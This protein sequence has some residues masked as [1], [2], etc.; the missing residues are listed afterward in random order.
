M[1]TTVSTILTNKT[2]TTVVQSLAFQEIIRFV[3][4]SK[5]ALVLPYVEGLTAIILNSIQLWLLVK[6]FPR[7]AS[8]LLVVIKHL[9]TSDLLNGVFYLLVPT[10][11]LIETEIFPENKIFLD[12]AKFVTV[13]SRRYVITVS[14]FLLC[15]LTLKKML[16]IVQNRSYTRLMLRNS[17]LSA[18][19]VTFALVGIEFVIEETDVLTTVSLTTLKKIWVPLVIFPSIILQFYCYWQIFIVVQ[20][21]S[22]RIP[23]RADGST[24]NNSSWQK[25]AAFQLLVFI[26]C[27][28]PLSFY[29]ILLV[30]RG[31]KNL[32]NAEKLTIARLMLLNNLNSIIDPIVFF[33]VFRKKW[34]RSRISFAVQFNGRDVG[35]AQTNQE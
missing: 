9:C 27:V 33:V 2:L 20:A 35:I 23:P 24:R 5:G 31:G 29:L 10:L 13:A 8:S 28:S 11:S 3:V 4:I 12:L 30:I 34:R 6:K 21:T 17:C 18:W 19:L 32:S 25:I 16:K 1:E 15:I 22:N 14:S 26:V 7:D